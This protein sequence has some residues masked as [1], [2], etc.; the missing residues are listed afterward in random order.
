MWARVQRRVEQVLQAKPFRHAGAVPPG[1]IRPGPGN[2]SEVA[3]YQACVILLKPLF[4]I[5]VPLFL[6]VLTT[7]E[8]LCRAMLRVVQGK[9]DHFMLESKDINKPG[10]TPS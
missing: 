7:S 1:A 6:S 2:R 3:A 5:F 9:A 10:A 4:P 8:R